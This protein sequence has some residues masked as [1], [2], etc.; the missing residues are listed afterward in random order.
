MAPSLNSGR[1]HKDVVLA[2]GKGEKHGNAP[3]ERAVQAKHHPTMPQ[4]GSQTRIEPKSERCKK[5]KTCARR[6]HAPG[7]DHLRH[8]L[9]AQPL[10]LAPFH[11]E[12]GR[13]QPAEVLLVDLSALRQNSEVTAR[14]G[15][16]ARKRTAGRS[17]MSHQA[18]FASSGH[19]AHGASKARF[20]ATIRSIYVAGEPSR[21]A[22]IRVERTLRQKKKQT[23]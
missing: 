22:R 7:E 10:A 13:A 19:I 18:C 9:V 6:M 15:G 4:N 8:D 16:R 21:R 17:K 2:G 1:Q 11:T 20:A 14:I 3:Q 12:H 5:K 23:R